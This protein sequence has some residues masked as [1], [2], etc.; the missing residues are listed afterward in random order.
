MR[1]DSPHATA[2][3]LFVVPKSIPTE[4]RNGI[5]RFTISLITAPIARKSSRPVGLRI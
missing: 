5:Y 1:T 3:A 4:H 2:M